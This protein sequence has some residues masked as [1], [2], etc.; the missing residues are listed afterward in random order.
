MR[1]IYWRRVVDEK[2]SVFVLAKISARSP[3]Q[4]FTVSK[5]YTQNKSKDQNIPENCVFSDN[6]I[7]N[8]GSKKLRV[9]IQV[10]NYIRWCEMCTMASCANSQDRRYILLNFANVLNLFRREDTS[11]HLWRCFLGIVWVTLTISYCYYIWSNLFGS[12]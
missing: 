5:V 4:L 10:W 3:W 9:F 8:S 6:N 2:S 1:T 12:E 7:M 11:G